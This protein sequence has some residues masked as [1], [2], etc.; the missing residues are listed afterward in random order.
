MGHLFCF[1]GWARA[2]GGGGLLMYKILNSQPFV[3]LA[4]LQ[5]HKH[6]KNLFKKGP[7]TL[8]MPEVAKWVWGRSVSSGQCC[9]P[10]TLPRAV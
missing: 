1:L 7:Y 4:Q 3:T 10:C 8:L 5:K 2:R 9:G 6:Y